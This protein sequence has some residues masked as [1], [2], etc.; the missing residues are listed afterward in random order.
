MTGDLGY[1]DNKKMLHIIGRKDNTIKI[2]GI[3]LILKKL[4]I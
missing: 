3:E 2:S 4:K 1:F